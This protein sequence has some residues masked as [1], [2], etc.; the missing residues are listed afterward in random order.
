M[1]MGEGSAAVFRKLASEFP[2]MVP[3]DE[4]CRSF[5][6]FIKVGE[7]EFR[8]SV[9]SDCSSLHVDRDLRGILKPC[10]AKVR[11]HLQRAS[12]AHQFLIELRDII[13]HQVNIDDS[14]DGFESGLPSAQFYE[15]LLGEI[16]RIGWDCVTSMNETM[17]VLDL[18]ITDSAGR[19]HAVNVTLPVDYPENQPKCITDLPVEFDAQWGENSSL[20]SIIR[21][22]QEL[23]EQYQDFFRSMEDIDKETW[24]LEPEHPTMRETYRRVALGKHCSMRV[25]IDPRAPVKGFPEVR[26]LGS[27]TAVGPFK[28]R[29]NRNIHLWDTSGKSLPRENLERVLAMTLPRREEEA[30]ST[31][32]D[33]T[34]ECGI[35][36]AYRL[37]DAVPD[38]LCDLAECS[39]PYHRACLV[40]WLRALP[41]TRESF[42][43]IT[44]N[45]VYCEET[46]SVSV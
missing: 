16:S 20:A 35:C 13:E 37:E 28:E 11:E 10:M 25:E 9:S 29:L 34:L 44:G 46:I 5:S 36:Y 21:Q 7:R 41:D 18:S 15:H 19:N 33:M 27:E 31:Q 22:F 6:G 42:G 4:H 32:E 40:E 17:R 23:V 45:C 2:C 1:M 24:V 39:K 43:T 8:L 14:K 30:G 12:N 26:F 3:S 38:V